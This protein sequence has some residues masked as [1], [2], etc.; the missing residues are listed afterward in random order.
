MRFRYTITNRMK[1]IIEVECE[2]VKQKTLLYLKIHTHFVLEDL[3]T[4]ERFYILKS[5]SDY[6]LQADGTLTAENLHP[7]AQYAPV[8]LRLHFNKQLPKQQALRCN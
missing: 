4:G 8:C 6:K 5:S 2:A 7:L 3:G 1:R